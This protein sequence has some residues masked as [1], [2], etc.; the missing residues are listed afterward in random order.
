MDISCC[1]CKAHLPRTDKR[2][3]RKLHGDSCRRTRD[4]LESNSRVPLQNLM[5]T[6]DPNA[7]LCNHCVRDLNNILSYQSKIDALKSSVME[8]LSVLQVVPGTMAQLHPASKRP[9]L[10]SIA[11]SS[12]AVQLETATLETSSH[13]TPSQLHTVTQPSTALQSQGA[14]Q[15]QS[16][17]VQVS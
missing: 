8:K 6:S 5:E 10:D 17:D 14:S 16:P 15:F 13:S 7:Y 11:S 9:R 2:N 3:R 12:T 1:L 4:V